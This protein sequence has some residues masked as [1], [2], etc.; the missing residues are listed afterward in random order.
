MTVYRDPFSPRASKIARKA[1]E[2]ADVHGMKSY[3]PAPQPLDDPR[4]FIAE[5]IEELQDG[6]WYLLRQ[7]A[8]LED[9]RGRIHDPAKR[10]GVRVRWR[11]KK[12][13]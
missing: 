4:D 9:L 12:L 3:G 13:C 1:I 8:K 2:R 7:I 6:V 5:A 11:P 10:E